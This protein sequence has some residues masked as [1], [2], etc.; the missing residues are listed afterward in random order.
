EATID[1]GGSTPPVGGDVAHGPSNDSPYTVAGSH[2]YNTPGTYT[3]TVT[4]RDRGGS[5]T[6]YVGGEPVTTERIPAAPVTAGAATVVVAGA[7][8][9]V[10]ALAGQLDP[11]SDTGISQTDGITR[12]NT[13]TFLGTAGPG[14]IV[15]LLA[16][17]LGGGTSLPLGRAVTDAAGNWGIDAPLIRDGSYQISASAVGEDGS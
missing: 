2:S 3:A 5:S 9:P 13:P 15:A 17:P 16:T 6:T 11:R 10:G 12:D 14:A 7:W 4:I 1:W 8:A